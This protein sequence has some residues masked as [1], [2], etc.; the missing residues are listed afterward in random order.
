M[1]AGK[2]RRSIRSRKAGRK[3]WSSKKPFTKSAKLS[4]YSRTNKQRQLNKS[5][6]IVETKK[7]DASEISTDVGLNL[8]GNPIL[9]DF[10]E[11]PRYLGNEPPLD[12]E[13][14]IANYPTGARGFPLR[15]SVFNFNPDSCLY[16]T[17]GIDN[18][19]M[20]G[21]SAYQKLCAAKF[22]IRWPQPTM[23]TGKWNGANTDYPEPVDPANPT[24][25]EVAAI[26]AWLGSAAN[27][28]MGLMPETPQSY[29]LYWGFVKTPYGYSDFTTP[30][31]DEADAETLER[32]INLRVEQWFNERTDRISFIPKTDNNLKIIGKKK[33]TPPWD[34]RN[35]RLPVSYVDDSHTIT[36]DILHEGVIPDTLVKITWPINKKIHFQE[37]NN[38]SGDGVTAAGAPVSGVKTFYQNHHWLPFACIVNWN[39]ATLPQNAARTADETN[40]GAPFTEAQVARD[41]RVPH[42]LVNDQTY[43]RDQ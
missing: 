43:Y 13:L 37:T 1:P 10:S 14:I 25:A 4:K 11:N 3:S 23:N 36:Q 38:F 42:V 40:D 31:R 22:L 7:T 41:R 20:I 39:A 29:H 16:Q 21:S 19:S 15:D 5:A 27:N 26:T 12:E 35:G 32:H 30:K 24:P 9:H 17:Q 34:S 33:L 18:N 6:P 28:W 8:L 2:I